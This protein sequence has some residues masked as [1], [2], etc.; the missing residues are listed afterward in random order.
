[1][2]RIIWWQTPTSAIF[3]IVFTALEENKNGVTISPERLPR[4]LKVK[5]GD[6]V[7]LYSPQMT[8]PI[9]QFSQWFE[10][11]KKDKG[12]K[13]P[14][15]HV[16]GKPWTVHGQPSARHCFAPRRSMAQRVLFSI[17][18]LESRKSRENCAKPESSAVFTTGCHSKN[19]SAFEGRIEPVSAAEADAY[20]SPPAPR[21]S[22]IGAWSSK[23]SETLASRDELIDRVEANSK[24]FKGRD[25]PRPRPSGPV[26]GWF[27]EMIEFWQQSDF[28]LHDREVFCEGT[29]G[30]EGEEVV[31]VINPSPRLRGRLGWG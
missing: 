28:R 22:Q 4:P 23:Q 17:P 18:I 25:I 26:G 6:S 5:A 14:T 31:S 15:A 16:P 8:D 10:K 27:P 20:F 21:E 11:A 29:G 9:A 13:E 7:A 19:K 3:R 12:I 30:V 1:M 24:K 2:Q